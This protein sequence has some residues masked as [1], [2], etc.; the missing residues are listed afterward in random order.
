MH[1]FDIKR[2]KI[3]T[4]LTISENDFSIF[5][6]IDYSFLDA[7]KKK[8]IDFFDENNHRHIIFYEL[9]LDALE[10]VF[11]FN[12]LIKSQTEVEMQLSHDF[13]K[14]FLSVKN[15]LYFNSIVSA[16][17]FL[18]LSLI[19]SK[20]HSFFMT[21]L[22]AF[23]Q[24]IENVIFEKD[25]DE[26]FCKL[27]VRYETP[28]LI[29]RNFHNLNADEI[30]ILVAALIGKNLRKHEIFSI[31]PNKH[32]FFSI[33]TLGEVYF[34]FKNNI[35]IRTFIMLRLG[36]LCRDFDFSCIFTHSSKEFEHNPI[37]YLKQFDFWSRALILTY[38]ARNL[39]HFNLTDMIDYLEYMKFSSND[40]YSLKGRTSVTLQRAAQIWH[41]R[42]FYEDHKLLRKLKWTGLPK[43]FDLSFDY[44]KNEYK[45]VQL[46]SGEEL[47]QEGEAMQHCVI[48]YTH[49][50]RQ[51][52]CTIWSL[53]IK[54]DI[55]FARILT[56]EVREKVIVQARKLQNR[57]PR[58]K[59]MEV[60]REWAERMAY[61]IDLYKNE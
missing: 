56:I 10:Q 28:L 43:E 26:L 15:R 58:K 57:L 5:D 12:D 59:D 38:G 32:E 39:R 1:L 25:M 52:H 60:L 4:D 16:Q 35:L 47:Y 31:K 24:K 3:F 44:K 17:K 23:F 29:V 8:W 30:D 33:M 14:K 27:L 9:S 41:G 13:Y 53:Q 36:M 46:I 51:S 37:R 45:C 19:Y 48:T 42:V 50:S 7:R 34:P 49:S 61:K 20:Y 2:Q 21:S 40:T 18:V 55:S 54:N 22:E 6:T 11:E